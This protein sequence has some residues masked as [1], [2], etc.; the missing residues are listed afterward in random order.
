MPKFLLLLV[1]LSILA[2]TVYG[3]SNADYAALPP[4]LPAM[5][6]PNVMLN[7]SIETPMQGAAYNDQPNNSDCN[8]RINDG[9][10]V[11]ICYSHANSYIGYFDPDKCYTYSN[12]RF[13]PA[14][15]AS[16]HRCSGQWS[17]NFLN[18]A[19]MTAIDEFRWAMT[20]GN[21]QTD[22]TTLTVL[23]RANMALG[24]GDSWY[25]VKMI[26]SSV[27]VAPSTV[28]PYSDSK[29]YI[30]NHNY[31]FDIG[32][33]WGGSQKA[34][35]LYA[36]VKVC[37]ST[38]A[39]EENCVPYSSYF[40]PQGLIQNNAY[41]MRFALMS[42][43]RDNSMSRHGGVLRA[44]MK[45]VGPWRPAAGGG[46]ES[47]PNAEFGSDGLLRAN[48][49]QVTLGAGVNDSGV[50]NYLNKFGANGYKSYDPVGELF[51]E[52]L[53]YFK[54]R[55]P[56]PEY[57]SGLSDSQKDGFPVLTSWSD[58]IQHACQQNFIVGINDANPW[59][60]K[61]LPGTAVTSNRYFGGSSRLLAQDANDF[62]N[63]G[64]AD[65]D[66]NATSWTN[67]VG[68]LEGLTGSAQCIGCT[69]TTCDM[70]ANNKVI[71]ALGRVFGSCPYPGKENSYYIAG[72]AYYARTQDLRADWS[73]K[74]S[75]SAFMVDTQEYSATP[76][77]GRMNMLWLAGKYGGFKEQD[78]QDSNG[79]GNNEEPN[80]ATEWDAD[81]DGQPDHYV[82][83][84][85]PSKLVDG[86]NRAFADIMERISA[87]TSASVVANSYTGTGAVYQA[88]YNP[89]VNANGRQMQWGGVLHALFIDDQSRFR[90]DGNSN[91]RL[92][93]CLSDPVVDI[94]YDALNKQTKIRRYSTAADC[95]TSGAS[96]QELEIEQ[97][98]PLWDARNMLAR[99]S[100][101]TSQRNYATQTAS[102]GRHITTWIDSNNNG[103]VESGEQINLDSSQFASTARYTFLR[104]TSSTEASNI[105]NFIRGQ[106]IS[107]FRSRTIDYNNSGT[108]KVWRLGDI[109]HSTPVAV[110]APG[111]TYGSRY[112]Q[113]YRD[114]SYA[115]FRNQYAKRRQV[116]YVGA[117]DGL[118]HA[119]NSGFWNESSK[120]FATTQG[121]ALAHALG[122]ELW[123]YAPFNLLPH[124]KWL[125]RLDYSHVYYMDGSPIAFDAN[126]F[127]PDSDHPGGWGTVL[128]AGMGLGG[129]NFDL[130]NNGTPDTRSAY[131]VLDI[132]NP[133]SPPKLLAEITHP[134]LGFTVSQPALLVRR[135]PAADGNWNNPQY[136]EWRLAFGS[137]PTQLA[138]VTSNQ[139]GQ[140]FVYDLRTRNWMSGFAPYDLGNMA[141][142]ASNNSGI[143]TS[144]I[145]A[146]TSIDWNLDF[147]TDALYFGS[148]G[149][150]SSNLSQSGRLFRM[151]WS[152]W[153]APT[154][155]SLFNP[156]KPFA[157]PPLAVRDS[158]G[159]HWLL[160]G[161]GRLWSTADNGSV[162]GQ[163]LYGLKAIDSSSE[164]ASSTL[165][166]V[167]GLLVT[168]RQTLL[169]TQA[170]LASLSPPVN[171][172]EAL[173]Q[174]IQAGNGWYKTLNTTGTTPSERSLSAI[175]Q[176]ERLATFTLYTPPSNTCEAE[177]SSSLNVLC[178][179]TGTACPPAALNTTAVS[180]G[181]ITT[182]DVVVGS[183]SIGTGIASAPV[184][185]R[186]NSSNPTLIT[187]S[188]TGALTRTT[189]SLPSPPNGRIAW[190][191]V[192]W[193]H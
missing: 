93:D 83:A 69:A 146:V 124:L 19:T 119:F 123:A 58:P 140:L 113:L 47:N 9:G 171:D 70:Q 180:V 89:K 156:G 64:N 107:G 162:S 165:Q 101:L 153:N 108:L 72:L 161:S 50:I 7:L 112:D 173:E 13:E 49:D 136:N 139:N 5:V 8:G 34:A 121:T 77:V 151:D 182:N 39:L 118:L 125:T 84:T 116:V 134:A 56:T 96:Y 63:P 104:A 163:T 10:T 166:N 164:I 111:E 71:N 30:Y 178:Y 41:R 105:V 87:G 53:N 88:L 98:R 141:G 75:L 120:S 52:C 33:S 131:V 154:V 82:L 27:N 186:G 138:T 48:P 73:G 191:E 176:I 31:Q 44:N 37:S 35:N 86:L 150:Q 152:N 43:S 179:T 46:L 193:D 110:A 40:K 147:T 78:Y 42:Y 80:L 168:S 12:N 1:V 114:S 155:T 55:G 115:T 135:A 170:V 94:Y 129:G 65:P 38:V 109:V 11:G 60:D 102:T 45:Y 192:D 137:G 26:A 76:L 145:P 169:D 126:I 23:E 185:H 14:S 143:A 158:T 189:V 24:Q 36:R 15:L 28:T 130:D 127:T 177:G 25:P 184:I 4:T 97:L 16:G 18:W 92:D 91:G 20:G 95:N 132:T 90:E 122:D 183:V 167:T 3:A 157:A 21:R 187:Q 190:R 160:A 67:L 61:R 51:Y 172:Y 54:H 22:T 85:D 6:D 149:L 188:S 117:N 103:Q 2:P 57:A 32:T 29:I 106:E 133:E 128:V 175:K 62:G 68:D 81:G 148:D 99:V 17:G 74:Q 79:D 66:I 59:L 100:N 144:F 142:A 159:N 174:T 181:G